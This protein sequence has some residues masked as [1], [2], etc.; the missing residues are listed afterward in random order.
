MTRR[1]PE[2]ALAKHTI[3]ARVPTDFNRELD[4]FCRGRS[5]SK[6]TV[7]IEGAKLYMARYRRLNEEDD[8]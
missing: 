1:K 6:S 5:L 7:L 2:E 3:S 8:T 4:E